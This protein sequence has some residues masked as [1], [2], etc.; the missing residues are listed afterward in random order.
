MLY[1][2][3]SGYLRIIGTAQK[4]PSSMIQWE[5]GEGERER[6]GERERTVLLI[7]CVCHKHIWRNPEVLNHITLFSW[8]FYVSMTTRTS[9]RGT[10][11]RRK[12]GLG[13]CHTNIFFLLFLYLSREKMGESF[14]LLVGGGIEGQQ[15]PLLVC[16]CCRY[17]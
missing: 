3:N 11:V 2:G 15:P 1:I 12:G 10:Y 5:R 8:L 4:L 14:W 17:G 13:L 9:L 6:V 7:Q 16:P